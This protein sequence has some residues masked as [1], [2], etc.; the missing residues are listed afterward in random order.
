VLLTRFI[1]TKRVVLPIAKHDQRDIRFL[2]DLIEDGAFTAVIDRRY[3][4]KAIVDA[5]RYVDTGQKTGTS[6]SAWP[7]CGLLDS[8]LA[9]R[10]A[11]SR[12]ATATGPH[13]QRSSFAAR[14]RSARAARESCCSGRPM[15]VKGPGPDFGHEFR[16]SYRSRVVVGAPQIASCGLGFRLGGGRPA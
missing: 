3:P 12:G 7:D 5:Y 4:L 13:Q 2:K 14:R 11:A 8:S 10:N 15:N 16:G 9:K 1:G 6:S